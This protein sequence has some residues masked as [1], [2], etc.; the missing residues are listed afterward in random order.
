M[1]P[2]GPSL[3][4]ARSQ[5]RGSEYIIRSNHKHQQAKL[6]SKLRES[7]SNSVQ[8]KKTLGNYEAINKAKLLYLA[9]TTPSSSKQG[10]VAGKQERID[11]VIR[12]QLL[13]GKLTNDNKDTI[14]GKNNAFKHLMKQEV[15]DLKQSFRS[16]RPQLLSE[17]VSEIEQD[18]SI[19]ERSSTQSE[20]CH[21]S[22]IQS[23]KM[24]KLKIKVSK[25]TNDFAPVDQFPLSH[26][27]PDQPKRVLDKN[28]SEIIRDLESE[29]ESMTSESVS[30]E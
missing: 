12:S 10:F 5:S 17:L 20:K 7:I 29:D 11:E 24:P 21:Q 27:V 26:L 22:S 18:S 15:D 13:V 6:S 9:E 3:Q 25:P 2:L 4:N 30:R 19:L 1:S 28:M 8:E 23:V 16:K 14:L